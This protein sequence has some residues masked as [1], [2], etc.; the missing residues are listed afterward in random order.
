[1]SEHLIRAKT[2]TKK[3]DERFVPLV[4]AKCLFGYGVIRRG[5]AAFALAEFKKPDSMFVLGESLNMG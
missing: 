1:M 4:E 2:K 3:I 5:V